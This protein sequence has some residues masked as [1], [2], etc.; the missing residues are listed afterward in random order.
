MGVRVVSS[1]LGRVEVELKLSPE[2]DDGSSCTAFITVFFFNVK[3]FLCLLEL[4]CV[5]NEASLLTW[6]LPIPIISGTV[7]SDTLG[8]ADPAV[9]F[10]ILVVGI[11]SFSLAR[12]LDAI[13]GFHRYTISGALGRETLTSSRIFSSC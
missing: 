13:I 5:V 8:V 3:S 7:F 6:A 2:N 11:N 9:P 10:G 12:V 4:P 1:I